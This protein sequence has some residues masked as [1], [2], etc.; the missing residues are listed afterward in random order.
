MGINEIDNDNNNPKYYKINNNKGNKPKNFKFYSKN[1]NDFEIEYTWEFILD[2]QNISIIYIHN[3][4]SNKRKILFNKR[5]I[6][7]EVFDGNKYTYEFY[8]KDHNYKIV[9]ENDIPDFYIYLK[10]SK[11]I[12]SFHKKKDNENIDYNLPAPEPTPC[13]NSRKIYLTPGNNN[14]DNKENKIIDKPDSKYSNFIENSHQLE[15]HAKFIKITDKGDYN[16]NFDFDPKKYK[17]LDEPKNIDCLIFSYFGR[18]NES[19]KYDNEIISSSE[20]N[21]REEEGNKNLI[22]S[23]KSNIRENRIED[24]YL[25]ELK[26]K[27]LK[28]S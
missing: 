25:K 22:D 13:D 17:H 10:Y 1:I 12:N 28:T 9:H 15:S 23:N 5:L 19:K 6:R 20:R 2:N 14:I 24:N 21:R 3:L 16:N 7:E 4:K 18:K 27:K 8:E 11:Y 26:K